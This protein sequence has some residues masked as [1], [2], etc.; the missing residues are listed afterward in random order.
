VLP[1]G[2]KPLNFRRADITS[3]NAPTFNL[4]GCFGRLHSKPLDCFFIDYTTFHDLHLSLHFDPDFSAYCSVVRC[5]P[6][7]SMNDIVQ[8][9]PGIV[10][11]HNFL[12]F[13]ETDASKP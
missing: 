11:V 6:Y 4:R 1:L 8:A 7:T 2:E 10:G 3:R 5:G 9:G 13:F 12:T